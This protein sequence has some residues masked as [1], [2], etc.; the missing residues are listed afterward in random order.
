MPAAKKATTEVP[1][2][3]VSEAELA[4]ARQI[5]SECKFTDW[6]MADK[7]TVESD[8]KSFRAAFALL[9]EAEEASRQKR[10]DNPQWSDELKKLRAKYE[11]MLS[12]WE[13]DLKALNAKFGSSMSDELALARSRYNSTAKVVKDAAWGAKNLPTMNMD[14]SARQPKNAPKK[15]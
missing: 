9:A 7:A 2:I 12:Q 6:L 1:E 10:E 8:A 5:V 3:K 4:S 14:G 13:A 15:K 11:P